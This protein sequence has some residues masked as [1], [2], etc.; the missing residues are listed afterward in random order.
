MFQ[1]THALMQGTLKDSI[2][3]YIENLLNAVNVQEV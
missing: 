3:G 2:I 1:F